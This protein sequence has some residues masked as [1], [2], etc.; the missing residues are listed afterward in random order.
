MGIGASATSSRRASDARSTSPSKASTS[1]ASAF[2][3]EPPDRATDSSQPAR[4]PSKPLAPQTSHDLGAP[5]RCQ[6]GQLRT[7]PVTPVPPSRE[8]EPRQSPMAGRTQ[9]SPEVLLLTEALPASVGAHDD[10]GERWIGEVDPQ[11]SLA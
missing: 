11:L 6:R 1:A 10:G 7:N 3:R 8:P 9:T 5:G 2:A 4:R